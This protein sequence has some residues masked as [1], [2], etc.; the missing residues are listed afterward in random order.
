MLNFADRVK[1]T[2]TTTGTGAITLSGTAPTQFVAFATAYAVPTN[3]IPYAIVG[4]S[5]TEWETGLGSLTAST[6]LTRDQINFSSNANA[7]VN[8][9][10][11]TKDVFV[12]IGATFMG[13][14]STRGMQEQARLGAFTP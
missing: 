1:D 6:T 3:R 14:A 7:A 4:Q 10:A 13:R 2:T 8:F 12:A 9:S 5:G 11:G